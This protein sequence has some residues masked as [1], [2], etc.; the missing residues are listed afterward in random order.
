[1]AD[2][3]VTGIPTKYILDPKGNICFKSVGWNG[4]AD[5]L[6]DELSLMIDLAKTR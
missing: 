6:V 2:F 3:G 1:V 5:A 4:S